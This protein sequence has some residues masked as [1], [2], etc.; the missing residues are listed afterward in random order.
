M[1][2]SHL[3][4]LI[5]IHQLF[6]TKFSKDQIGSNYGHII[7]IHHLP[8]WWQ[9]S[10]NNHLG[11]V[12]IKHFAKKHHIRSRRYER[13]YETRFSKTRIHERLPGWGRDIVVLWNYTVTMN[14]RQVLVWIHM[15]HKHRFNI[16]RDHPKPNS[17]LEL[18]AQTF[19]THCGRVTQIC[20]FNTVKLGTSASSP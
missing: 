17:S 19:L 20:V 8:P 3:C 4:K 10:H 2:K 18:Q 16:K 5:P 1:W 13:A 12:K 11:T 9:E 7:L 14:L 15:S 6:Y